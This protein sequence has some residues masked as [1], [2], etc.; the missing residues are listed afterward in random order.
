MTHDGRERCEVM[1]EASKEKGEDKMEV[2]LTRKEKNMA[3]AEKKCQM[4]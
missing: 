4:S 3:L 2:Q 1:G